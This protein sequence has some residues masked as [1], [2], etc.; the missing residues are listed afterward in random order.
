[1]NT[2]TLKNLTRPERRRIQWELKKQQGKHNSP[3]YTLPNRKSDLKTIDEEKDAIRQTAEKTLNVYR[4]LLPG[5][6]EKLSCIPDPRNPNKIKHKMTVILLYGI[7]M[8]VYQVSSRRKANQEITTPLLLE[9]LKAVFP[10]IE[11]MPHQ[12][13]LCRLLEK[14]DVDS[15]ETAYHELLKQNIRKKRFK[16]MLHK[17]RYRKQCCFLTSACR[18]E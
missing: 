10:E 7:L 9:N 18:L 13:T 16:N 1:M 15:I 8:F 14:M 12:S 17:K 11:D 2:S 6:L 4:Q 5:L 3:V